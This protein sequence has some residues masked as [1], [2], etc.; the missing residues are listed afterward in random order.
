[1]CSKTLSIHTLSRHTYIHACIH[2]WIL[3]QTHTDHTYL[4]TY[5]Q[6]THTYPSVFQQVACTWQLLG[7]R[8]SPSHLAHSLSSMQI[9]PSLVGVLAENMYLYVCMRIV[10]R[11]E[12]GVSTR[13]FGSDVYVCVYVCMHACFVNFRCRPYRLSHL[14]SQS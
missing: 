5:I 12:G 7:L 1:M 11:A 3:I 13:T 10:A 2:T 8:Y 6:I 9:E 4:H 14:C